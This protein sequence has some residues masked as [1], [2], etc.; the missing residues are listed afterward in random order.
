M[1]DF[2][3]QRYIGRFNARMAI[4]KE[5]TLTERQIL[6]SYASLMKEFGSWKE[7]AEWM[8]KHSP[9]LATPLFIN[10]KKK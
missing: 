6:K 8:T 5:S 3:K 2:I 9:I 4:I 10:N 7:V 1:N